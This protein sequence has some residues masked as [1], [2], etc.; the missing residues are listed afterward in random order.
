MFLFSDK[1]YSATLDNLSPKISLLNLQQCSHISY[2]SKQATTVTNTSTH[3]LGE[4]C[5]Q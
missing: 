1:Y 5:R 2:C 3:P 4:M